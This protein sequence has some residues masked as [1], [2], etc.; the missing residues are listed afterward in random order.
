M[1][2]FLPICTND[3]IMAASTTESSPMYT[4][5]PTFMGMNA[6]PLLAR[7]SSASAATKR[8]HPAHE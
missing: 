2:Q 5:S 1:T 7:K 8:I 6:M 4:W 3:P